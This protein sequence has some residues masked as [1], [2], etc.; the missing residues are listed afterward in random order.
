MKET[1]LPL[2]AQSGQ[3]QRDE[4]EYERNGTRNLFLCVEP[5]AG[6]RHVQVTEQRTKR[7]CA[8][9]MQWRVDARYPEAEVIRVTMDN[10]N[11]HKLAP[12]YEAFPPAEARRMARKLE[13]HDTPKHGS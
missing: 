13:L 5:H 10:L 6:W 1:R 12:L 2:P 8:H 11:T 7:N 3:P 4:Y 9:Q